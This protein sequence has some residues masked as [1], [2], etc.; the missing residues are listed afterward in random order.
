VRRRGIAFLLTIS[1]CALLAAGIGT[2]LAGGKR[3]KGKKTIAC[4][5][6]LAAQEFPPAGGPGFD[7]GQITCTRP[8]GFGMQYDTFVITPETQT[9]GSADLK[10]KAFFDGG[11][12][13]GTWDVR[14]VASGPGEIA[15]DIDVKLTKGTAR[16][17]GVSGSGTGTGQMTDQSHATFKFT[18][19]VAGL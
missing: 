14:Y 6:K 19:K 13:S 5:V 4:T 8:L 18:A 12:I 2:A 17:R 11:R 15:Y 7:Y 10:F 16:F 1:A 3:G 9:T